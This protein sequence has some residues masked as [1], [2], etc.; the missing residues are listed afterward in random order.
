MALSKRKL[1]LLQN[2]GERCWYCGFNMPDDREWEL[3]HQVPRSR[4]GEDT[5]EN[6][7]L[8]CRD[9]NRR[10]KAH[11]VNEYRMEILRQIDN[12]LYQASAL[13]LPFEVQGD[14]TAKHMS[15][16]LEAVRNLSFEYFIPRF[17][18]EISFTLARIHDDVDYES[19]IPA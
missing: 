6:I 13:L 9:C 2:Q 17:K 16:L 8:A 7:V 11:T 14:R 18:G 4:G 19:E 10:K 5:E 1:Q 3:E 12:H 15:D